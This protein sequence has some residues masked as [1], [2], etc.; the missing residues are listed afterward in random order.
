M[1]EN[2]LFGEAL[3]H[4]RGGSLDRV[5]YTEVSAAGAPSLWTWSDN[6]MSSSMA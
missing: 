6:F 5:D 1:P 4:S 3:A 2:I